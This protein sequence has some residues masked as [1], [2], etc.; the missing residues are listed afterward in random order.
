MGN[1]SQKNQSIFKENV[2]TSRKLNNKGVVN[3]ENKD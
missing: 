1:D 3:L 2:E